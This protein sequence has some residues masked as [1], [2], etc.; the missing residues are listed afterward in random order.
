MVI[1]SLLTWVL[2][3]CTVPPGIYNGPL[4]FTLVVEPDVTRVSV[5]VP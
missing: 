4:L 2:L 3:Q 5:H 1:Y